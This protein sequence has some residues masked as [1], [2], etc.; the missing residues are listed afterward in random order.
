MIHRLRVI[1]AALFVFLKTD[2]EVMDLQRTHSSVLVIASKAEELKKLFFESAL[3][4]VGKWTRS[5]SDSDMIT[6]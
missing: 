3:E 1:C 5:A 2:R 6:T 4:T